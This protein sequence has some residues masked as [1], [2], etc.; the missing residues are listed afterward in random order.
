MQLLEAASILVSMNPSASVGDNNGNATPAPTASSGASINDSSS[1]SSSSEDTPPPMDHSSSSTSCVDA[2]NIPSI[3]HRTRPR[4]GSKRYSLSSRVERTPHGHGSYN[5]PPILVGPVPTFVNP[6]SSFPSHFGN[7][8]NVP[9]PRAGSFVNSNK[10][11]I[12]AASA[13]DDEGL[14]A[15]VELLSCSFGAAPS[16]SAP[17]TPRGFLTSPGGFL[18]HSREQAKK[19]GTGDIV[20]KLEELEEEE[21]GY[22]DGSMSHRNSS[23]QSADDEMA[24]DDD[25]DYDDWG[26]RR[27]SDGRMHPKSIFRRPR[28]RSEEDEDGIFGKME[29]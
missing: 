11:A 1:V 10:V 3:P 25:D 29:E 6:G 12:A 17:S 27:G 19:N 28:R 13:A 16:G 18:P 15:A 5:P 9:R 14:A 4:S 2:E 24:V 20:M 23:Q 21:N 8:A 7:R 26:R 22:Y